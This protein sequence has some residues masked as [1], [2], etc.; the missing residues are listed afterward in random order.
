MIDSNVKVFI[1]YPRNP[2]SSSNT[3][4]ELLSWHFMVNLNICRVIHVVKSILF[5][6][7]FFTPLSS[8][9]KLLRY[10]DVWQNNPNGSSRFRNERRRKSAKFTTFL[11]GQPVKIPLNFVFKK[12]ATYE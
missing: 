10:T 1:R 12:I 7:N 2:F 3:I 5:S 8:V 6:S 11:C 4:F 9:L